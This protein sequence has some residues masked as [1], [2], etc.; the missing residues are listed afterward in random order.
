MKYKAVVFDYAGVVAGDPGYV[1]DQNVAKIMGVTI[2]DFKTTY[3]HYND[4]HNTGKISWRDLWTLILRDLDKVS[5]ESSLFEFIQKPKSLNQSVV[6]LIKEL[7][8]KQYKIVLLSNYS[9][10][11]ATKIRHHPELSTLFDLMLISGE[12]GLAKP[13][14]EAYSDLIKKL[15]FQADQIIFIDDSPKNIKTAKDMGIVTILC[16]NIKTLRQ[17]LVN[18]GVFEKKQ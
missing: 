2:K 5:T 8:Q 13:H 4:L 11:G 9:R 1:F 10:D 12:T 16:Q 18:L 15:G 17:R 6:D 7:K 3:Y 14:P